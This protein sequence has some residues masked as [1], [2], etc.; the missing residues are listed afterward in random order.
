MGT[1]THDAREL[2]LEPRIVL[3]MTRQPANPLF[4]RYLTFQ[5]Y[6]GRRKRLTIAFRKTDTLRW[7]SDSFPDGI[8]SLRSLAEQGNRGYWDHMYLESQPDTITLP[9]KRLTI[10]MCYHDA[11]GHS[12]E[13]LNHKEIAIVDWPINME[14]LSVF[15]EICLDE[16]ARRSRYAWCDVT[17]RDPLLVRR[18]AED[19][20]KSGSDGPGQDQF[21]PNPKYGQGMEQ[22]CSEFVSWYYHQ[23]GITLN[24]QSLH[25][26]TSTQQMHD[27]FAAAGKLYRYDSGAGIQAFAHAATNERYTPRPG[28]L[29]ERRGADGAEHAMIMYRWLPG[30]PHAA[31]AHNRYNR[32]IVFNGPWPVTLRLVRIQEDEAAGGVDFWLGRIY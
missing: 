22:L 24:G 3:E 2:P 18:V 23:G 13:D 30:E 27:L 25:N 20:G 6:T 26:I 5:N 8:D 29:V 7:E 4:S 28:D 9:I 32:A 11:P 14:L 12:P 10:A 31:N 15:D 19:V 1:E 17:V 21:G 16:F